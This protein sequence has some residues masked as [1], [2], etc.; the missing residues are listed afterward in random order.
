MTVKQ[1]QKVIKQTDPAPGG[2]V[3]RAGAVFCLSDALTQDSYGT[4]YSDTG[5]KRPGSLG[6]SKAIV[7]DAAG[8]DDL[9]GLGHLEMSGLQGLEEK[10]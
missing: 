8:M 6:G 5:R 10:G 2:P 9:W 7:G 3:N 1:D 4:T